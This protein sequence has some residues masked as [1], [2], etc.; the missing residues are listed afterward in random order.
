MSL[1]IRVDVVSQDA[2]YFIALLGNIGV[3]MLNDFLVLVEEF[4][5]LLPCLMKRFLLT[6]HFF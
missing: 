1:R 6:S 2:I 3:E 4:G 5:V